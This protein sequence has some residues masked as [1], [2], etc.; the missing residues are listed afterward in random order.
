MKQVFW[1]TVLVCAVLG[2]V[3]TDAG[4]QKPA[5]E[6]ATEDPPEQPV[7]GAASAPATFPLAAPA[8]SD[9]KSLTVAPPGAMNQGPFDPATWKV[10]A[11]IQPAGGRDHLEPREAEDASG[12][13]GDRRHALLSYGSGNVLRDGR[14]RLRL[15]LDRDA[16]RPT[17]L[18]GGR[19]YVAYVSSCRRGSRRSGGRNR[20]K[21][22]PA[23]TRR[24]SSRHC[25]AHDRHG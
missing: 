11:C 8:G 19:A 1:A 3:V 4:Q 23:R 13:Q 17:R 15:R 6:S 18:A 22:N 5:R 10:R 14:C 25:G 12:R 2:M 9:S 7:K 16:T 20:R 21:G 24:R